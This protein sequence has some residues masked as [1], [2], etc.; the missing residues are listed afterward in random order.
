MAVYRS[1]QT[2]E[3]QLNERKA[4]LQHAA[5]I[6]LGVVKTFGDQANAGTLT[7]AQA[8][9][10]AADALRS[11]QFGDNGYFVVVGPKKSRR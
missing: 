4:D 9:S 11:L 6:A 3:T 1:Y 10:R 2:K 8:K 7:D 5:Q